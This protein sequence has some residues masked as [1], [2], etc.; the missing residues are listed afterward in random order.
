[1]AARIRAGAIGV[2]SHRRAGRG[3]HHGWCETA[4]VLE[5]SQHGIGKSGVRHA[6]VAADGFGRPLQDVIAVG[7]NGRSAVAKK[8]LKAMHLPSDIPELHPARPRP[9]PADTGRSDDWLN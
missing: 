8:I 5:R 4:V 2:T 7:G 3:R 6:K 9:P 1:M